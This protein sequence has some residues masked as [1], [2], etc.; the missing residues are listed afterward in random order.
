[1]IFKSEAE[2]Q[3]WRSLTSVV[4]KKAYIAINN[5]PKFLI[6]PETNKRLELDFWLPEYKVAFEIQG[7][8][9]FENESQIKRDNI[10]LIL[11]KNKGITLIRIGILQN[12]PTYIYELLEKLNKQGHNIPL[13]QPDWRWGIRRS[14]GEK[15]NYNIKSK[16]GEHECQVIKNPTECKIAE[17]PFLIEKSN[18]DGITKQYKIL[19]EERFKLQIKEVSKEKVFWIDKNKFK[20]GQKNNKI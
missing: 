2:R 1:M 20:K 4:S 9:H 6:N 11:C 10:K 5:K 17:F 16:Y 13:N 18:I 14:W 12:N 3:F 7:P 19:K 15:Y 8:S